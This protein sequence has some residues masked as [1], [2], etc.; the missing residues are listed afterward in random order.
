MS[1]YDQI[2]A[3]GVAIGFLYALSIMSLLMMVVGLAVGESAL[4][5]LCLLMAAGIASIAR[6]GITPGFST[7][8]TTSTSNTSDQ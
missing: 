8:S 7:T 6:F 4:A 2:M 5:M 3:C 1:K